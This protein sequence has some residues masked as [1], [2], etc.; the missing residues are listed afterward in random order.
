MTAH[1]VIIA[2]VITEKSNLDMAEG[3]YTFRV[4]KSSSKTEVKKAVEED[5]YKCE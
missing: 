5:G 1:D 4:N 2:P 3:K